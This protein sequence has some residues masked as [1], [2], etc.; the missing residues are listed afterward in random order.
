MIYMSETKNTKVNIR[1]KEEEYSIL[2]FFKEYVK[3]SGF[4][5]KSFEDKDIGKL[6]ISYFSKKDSV[7]KGFIFNNGSHFIRH[8][9]NSTK[10]VFFKT[11]LD[12]GIFDFLNDKT[13]SKILIVDKDSEREIEK[14]QPVN[15]NEKRGSAASL[16]KYVMFG[17][18][19][20]P[21]EVANIM[22]GYLFSQA[23]L[24]ISFENRSNAYIFEHAREKFVEGELP[25]IDIKNLD[26][27][28]YDSVFDKVKS[29]ASFDDALKFAMFSEMGRD[30]IL[31]RLKKG[32]DSIADSHSRNGIQPSIK[33]LDSF[34]TEV[35]SIAMPT[36][37]ARKLISIAFI[38]SSLKR[39]NSQ[40]LSSS[41]A[42][43]I[44]EI[45]FFEA[46]GKMNANI[47]KVKED[48]ND[49]VPIINTRV[50]EWKKNIRNS[51]RDK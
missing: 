34:S 1:L 49:L 20:D 30:E 22:I 16:I 36:I 14:L 43:N 6:L 4:L 40:M 12:L 9:G 26:I 13:E 3:A 10:T 17:I 23:F 11:L 28:N 18:I 5:L 39:N 38:Y 41:I 44:M 29:F 31:K 33:P 46:N 8:G 51:S 19:T 24:L 32:S 7:N 15:T 25:D 37:I 48:F 50:D 35:L 21:H 45:L 2:D 47:E 27:A 42:D